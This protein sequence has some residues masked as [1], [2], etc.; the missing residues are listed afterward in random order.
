[1]TV[2]K[3]K[4][5][6]R[7]TITEKNEL[8]KIAQEWGTSIS[9]VLRRL[10]YFF[11]HDKISVVDLVRKIENTDS[12]E[13]CLYGL[14]VTLTDI[15]KQCFLNAIKDWDFSASSILRRLVRALLSGIIQKNELWL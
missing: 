9:Y 3:Q 8:D 11:I 15:E 1:M 14:Q 6:T 12:T 5:N 13:E 4:I 10:I 7:L 2:R